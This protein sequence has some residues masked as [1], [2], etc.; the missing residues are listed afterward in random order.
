MCHVQRVG[1]RKFLDYHHQ[2]EFV[3]NDG[4][5]DQRPS[6]I[7]YRG[8][9]AQA[10]RRGRALFRESDRHLGQMFWRKDRGFVMNDQP[11]IR[12]VDHS[13]NPG[14]RRTGVPQQAKVQGFRGR[15]HDFVEGD[16]VGEH[17]FGIDL[18]L[19][20]LDALTPYGNI[21][22]SRNGHE[23]K[24]YL[25]VSNHRKIHHIVDLGGEPDLQDPAGRGQGLQH[26]R[27]SRGLRQFRN[28]QFQKL[29]DALPRFHD[30]FAHLEKKHNLRKPPGRGGADDVKARR[31]TKRILHRNG[32]QLFHL[33]GGHSGAFC[34]NFYFWG[35]ELGENIDGHVA[36]LLGSKNQQRHG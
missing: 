18:N 35:S 22:Y 26:H 10:R 16:A 9:I 12:G 21:S 31:S 20:G 8:D 15:F 17:E 6:V 19:Q 2:P 13:I 25:P 11:L 24:L 3:I 34:L 27:H 23:A 7:L 30:V 4:I 5:A 28:R 14:L 36:Q 32:D 1:P 29:L 33:G